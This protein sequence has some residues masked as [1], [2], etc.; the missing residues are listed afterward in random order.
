MKKFIILLV[1]LLSGT[2][3]AQ[4]MILTGQD[5]A[6]KNGNGYWI[7]NQDSVFWDEDTLYIA[8]AE[9]CEVYVNVDRTLGMLRLDGTIQNKDTVGYSS[10][11]DT[12][13]FY[14]ARFK[15]TF[16]QYGNGRF[17]PKNSNMSETFYAMDSVKQASG[18][19]G[20]FDVYPLSNSTLDDEA[21]NYFI[22]RITGVASK[23]SAIWPRLS[24]VFAY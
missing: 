7:S 9:T 17:D 15:G 21:C 24:L 2:V 14:C 6:E 10:T 1:V 12:I 8:G 20:A 13:R 11:G 23:I 19:V 18:T 5:V 22:F 3:L 4:N 16:R